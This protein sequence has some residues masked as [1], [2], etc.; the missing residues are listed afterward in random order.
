[1]SWAA[2]AVV[3]AQCLQPVA[4][5][6]VL[7]LTPVPVVVVSLVETAADAVCSAVAVWVAVDLHVAAAATRPHK[8]NLIIKACRFGGT[9]FFLP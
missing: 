5:I 2:W 3:V 4:A 8:A 6:L 1:M 7:V 9:L